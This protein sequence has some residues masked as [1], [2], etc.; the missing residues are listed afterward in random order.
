MRTLPE[1]QRDWKWINVEFLPPRSL[2]ARAMKLAMVDPANW[3]GELVTHSVSKSTRLGKPEVMRIR[4]QAATHQTRL[5]QHELPV[6]FI[7]QAD[8]FAQNVRYPTARSLLGAHR[9]SL[10]GIRVRSAG[11]C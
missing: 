9:I 7:A 8:R 11:G 6:V 3:D 5:P 4:R 10:V 1:P 2:I